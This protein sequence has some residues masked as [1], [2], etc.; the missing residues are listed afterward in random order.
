MTT[1]AK[2]S[3]S[4]KQK[5]LCIHS[6]LATDKL[7]NRTSDL[8]AC[9]EFG[10]EDG[11]ITL[12]QE[13]SLAPAFISEFLLLTINQH[14][15]VTVCDMEGCL[16]YINDKFC[17][18]SMYSR[19]EL[20][21]NGFHFFVSYKHLPVCIQDLWR[22]SS[23]D[24][25]WH[26]ELTFFAKDGTRCWVESSI[27]RCAGSQGNP[28]QYIAVHNDITQRKVIEEALSTSRNELRE[29]NLH[30]EK[31]AENERKRIAR[32]IHD[33]LGQYL[34]ALKSDVEMLHIRTKQSHPRLHHK[35]GL[36][37]NLIDGTLQR[38]RSIIN[39]L[40]PAILDLG[41]IAAIEW[42]VEGFERRTGIACEL[43][44][45][46]VRIKLHDAQI[47]T[48]FRVLQ[49]AL[50]NAHRH[51]QAS[52]III[53]LRANDSRLFIDVTDNGI[54]MTA[55]ALQKRQSF[56]LIGM[57]ERL[58]ALGGGLSITSEPENG[59]RLVAFIPMVK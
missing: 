38:V 54:G 26:G 11:D 53:A 27:M 59:T 19:S 46:N 32:E 20:M 50:L 6:A 47:L 55:S 23:P 56:G 10:S 13:A 12:G 34:L 9:C 33:D 3:C 17:A 35:A 7:K 44:L 4:V 31:I 1:S 36:A 58:T 14:A 45:C 8:E 40:R 39:D 2:S 49:E 29:L 41:L 48:L 42:Q 15:M 16:T 57:R 25:V 43:N 24:S 28:F 52:K 51:A 22:T 37:M 21:T 18:T 5:M 30:L